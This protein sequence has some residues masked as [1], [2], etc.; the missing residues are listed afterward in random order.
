M[1]VNIEIREEGGELHGTILQ[2][3]RAASGGRAEVFAPGSVSWPADGVA[4]L[5]EHL[6]A[7]ETRAFPHRDSLGRIKIR[8]RATDAIKSAIETGKR[9]MSIEF[10][11]LEERKTASGVREILRAFVE[12][13]ALVRSPEFDSTSAELR[14]KRRRRVWL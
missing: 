9:F 2:E 6:G 12:S 8:A 11:S 14:G 1:N 5:T 7:S 13:A 3:G 4:I 10:R